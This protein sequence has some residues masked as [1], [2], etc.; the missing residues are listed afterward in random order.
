MI[1]AELRRLLKTSLPWSFAP[2]GTACLG[3]FI[4][5]ISCHSIIS[6]WGTV[7]A[8]AYGTSLWGFAVIGIGFYLASIHFKAILLCC[9]FG[10]IGVGWTY[11]AISIML[12]QELPKS[13]FIR[14]AIGPLGFASGTAVFIGLDILFEI[15]T[16]DAVALG[17][18]I[19]IVGAIFAIVGIATMIMMSGQSMNFEE[20]SQPCL[21]FGSSERFLSV[22]LFFS[23]LPGMTALS[24][25]LHF[26]AY[27]TVRFWWHTLHILPCGMFFILMGCILAPVMSPRFGPRAFFVTLFCLQSLFL[28]L[29]SRVQTTALAVTTLFVILFAHGAGFS[30]ITELAK[31][32]TSHSTGFSPKYGRILA[33][34]GL[35]G[36]SG[37]LLSSQILRLSGGEEIL[38]FVIGIVTLWFGA[39]LY[40]V[41][42]FGARSLV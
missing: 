18:R 17:V 2:F 39:T 34:W 20:T 32:Q 30:I 4:G 26:S 28:I 23:A 11:L 42:F 40:F 5:L 6:G 13:L 15:S 29:L 1:Q 9:F 22:L 8:A 14:N 19:V 21:R 10:G 36:A 3:L 37:C 41:P 12:D 24:T 31:H 33:A 7:A 25:V 38:S 16:L 35:A 27:Y